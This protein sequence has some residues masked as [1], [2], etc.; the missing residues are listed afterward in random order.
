M[1][2]LA[3]VVIANVTSKAIVVEK[4]ER[5]ASLEVVETTAI[6]SI[7]DNSKKSDKNPQCTNIFNAD[8]TT[9][10]EII[11]CLRQKIPKLEVDFSPFS[12]Q[13]VQQIVNTLTKYADVF[14][15]GT[16]KYGAAK[17]VQ[18]VLDAGSATPI[19][20]PPHRVSPTDKST[21]TGRQCIF[22]NLRS[23]CRFL[24]DN[25]VRT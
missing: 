17:D 24:A 15:D 7:E 2:E 12:D 18:H 10:Q 25:D 23:I 20:Q 4:Q 3:L 14:D 13:E 8:A 9:R 11:A 1:S 5:L 19:I 6:T 16:S 22:F 21:H